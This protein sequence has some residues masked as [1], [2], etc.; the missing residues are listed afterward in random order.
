MARRDKERSLHAL[1]DAIRRD[2]FYRNENMGD[3]FVP[4]DGSMEDGV[5]VLI[6]EAPGRDEEREGKPFVGAAGRNLNALLLENG[7]A[8]K[9]LFITNLLKYR[10]RTSTGANRS[11]A[12]AECRY[13]LP[14]L[15]RE[16][17]I[18]RPGLAVCLG[19]SPAKALLNDPHL[20]MGRANG[21]L[22]R[23]AGLNILVTYHPSPFNFMV[24]EKSSALRR[25]FRQV[26]VRPE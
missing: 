4:G 6:G 23:G 1:Y 12:A 5:I 17:D 14:F 8:R 25:A 24:P 26:A 3:V 18:L 20:K 13:A 11:P 16:L 7:L 2:A 10:P 22:F 19:L 21:A 9:D 15:E